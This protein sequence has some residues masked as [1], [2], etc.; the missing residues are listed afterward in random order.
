MTIRNLATLI[1]AI[2]MLCACTN[3]KLDHYK[4]T[5]PVASIEDFFNGPLKGW[6]LVQDW[7]G[8]VTV[9]FDVEMNGKWEGN[10]GTLVEKFNYYDG[11]T[12]ERIWTI[13]KLENG[14][15]IGK[16]DDILGD[17]TGQSQGNAVNWKYRMDLPVGNKTYRVTF[18]D[19]MWQMNNGVLLNRSYIKKFGVTVAELTI[20]MQKQDQE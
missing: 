14:Q 19:W 12:Q 5:T 6:G 8:R 7:K 16:A 11:T 18:D 20:F 2:T 15:Y 10:T 9:R 13:T 3:N 1:G 17:A 4:N